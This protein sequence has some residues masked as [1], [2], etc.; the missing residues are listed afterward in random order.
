MGE[1]SPSPTRMRVAV[2]CPDH[3]GGRA[4]LTGAEA[5]VSPAEAALLVGVEGRLQ[6]LGHPPLHLRREP[7][8]EPAGR[9]RVPGGDRLQLPPA[10]LQEG[11][12]IFLHQQ[13]G[14]PTAGCVSL[15]PKDLVAV[16]RW[17]RPGTK[18]AMGP[19]AWR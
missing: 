18:I 10:H 15:R 8:E 6:P 2:H 7:L 19:A 14:G 9:L 17:L 11:Q 4:K 13:T 16:L 3:S 5:V 12:R 1:R